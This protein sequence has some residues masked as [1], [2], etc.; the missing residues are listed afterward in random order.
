VPDRKVDIPEKINPVLQV[1]IVLSTQPILF[2]EICLFIN[3]KDGFDKIQA[4][5]S[6]AIGW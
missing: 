2:Q 6:C 5:L 4:Q 1:S 3:H